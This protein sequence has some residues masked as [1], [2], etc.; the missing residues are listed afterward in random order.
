VR[1]GERR[2]RATLEALRVDALENT[3]WKAFDPDAQWRI[4]VD[5]AADL[6]HILKTP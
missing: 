1:G 6:D 4:D 2:L 5:R 3:W